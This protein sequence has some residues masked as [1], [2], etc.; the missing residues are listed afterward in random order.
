MAVIGVGLA[1]HRL[2]PRGD[3]Q[4]NHAIHTAALT[5]IAHD[6]PGRVYYERKLAEGKTKKEAM[7][8]LKRRIS[9]VIYRQLLADTET[10]AD[11]RAAPSPS[12]A[13]P[14]PRAR[15]DNAGTTR[16]SSVAGL[17]PHNSRLF[18]QV[19]PGPHTTLEPAARE[20]PSVVFD[21]PHRPRKPALDTK[22][23]RCGPHL[24]SGS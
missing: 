15:E 19:T 10:A 22:R 9:D 8:A 24:R 16:E 23:I 20:T 18:G 4:H 1:R 3:R 6:H 12:L 7:R 11:S 5:Q 14:R 13:V 17:A 2:N 21:A